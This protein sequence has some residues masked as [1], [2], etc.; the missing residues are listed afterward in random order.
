[1]FYGQKA[2]ERYEQA[3]LYEKVIILTSR[4]RE[5][6]KFLAAPNDSSVYRLNHRRV[7]GDLAT[8]LPMLRTQFAAF[9]AH[10]YAEMKARGEAEVQE[11]IDAG[12]A[13]EERNIKMFDR[14]CAQNVDSTRDVMRRF[15]KNSPEKLARDEQYIIDYEATRDVDVAE[16]RERIAAYKA[17]DVSTFAGADNTLTDPRT[18]HGR[19][20]RRARAAPGQD[21]EA[22]GAANSAAQP[23][24]QPA[25]AQPA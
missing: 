3:S 9:M 21:R 18:R 15:H 2:H 25:A 8:A 5:W 16:C 17:G 10:D 7:A 22:A 19:G 13:Q 23:A 4:V 12:V 24:S 1:M 11:S 14:T 6:T 20:E